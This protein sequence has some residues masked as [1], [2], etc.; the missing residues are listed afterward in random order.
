[1]KLNS[2]RTNFIR[3]TPVSPHSGITPMIT[4]ILLNDHL[5]ILQTSLLMMGKHSPIQETL[6]TPSTMFFWRKSRI[7]EHRPVIM[8]RLT[9]VSGLDNFLTKE[10]KTYQYLLSERYHWQCW[11]RSWRR[12]RAIEAAELTILMASA[13]ACCTTYWRRPSPSC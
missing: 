4:W 11:K 10:T 7:F 13:S 8:L 2:S 12:G 3:K 6:P 1:M 5:V 9:P